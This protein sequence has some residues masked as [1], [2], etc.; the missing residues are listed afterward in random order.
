MCFI[1]VALST[2]WMTIFL[3]GAS[4]FMSGSM[5]ILNP[6]VPSESVPCHLVATATAFTPACGELMGGVLRPLL[7]EV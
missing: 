1:Q 7:L 3:A 6:V 5:A 4:F 2:V